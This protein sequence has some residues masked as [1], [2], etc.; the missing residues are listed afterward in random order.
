[1][2][3]FLHTAD[4]QLGKPFARVSDPDK[5][6]LLRQERIAAIERIAVVAREQHAAFVLVAGDIFDSPVATKETVS[7]ACA[8]IGA[9]P[10]P[11]FAI[12]GNHDH[13]GPGSIWEQPF[14]FSEKN[15]LAP[16]LTVCLEAKP[17]ELDAAVLLPCPLLR[18]HESTDTTAWLRG[19]DALPDKP[20]IV[21][22]H[23]SVRGFSTPSEDDDFG[24]GDA[25]NQI[26][27]TRLPAGAF[28]YVALGDWHGKKQVGANA[29]Y[30]G[31]PE[32]DRFPRG[33]GNQ[34][35]HVLVVTVDRGSVPK[36]EPVRTARIGWYQHSENLLDDSDLS[37]LEEKVAALLGSRAQQDLLRLELRGQ[38][39]IEA[40]TQL[41]QNL[42]AWRARLLRLKL[43]RQIAVAPSPAEIESLTRRA[44]DPL[45]SRVSEKLLALTSTDNGDATAHARLAL[46]E[47]HAACHQPELRDS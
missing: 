8:A 20:R 45:I 4:W 25:V 24:D 37:G 3:T 10:V 21:L 39:G 6:A 34:P 16:N 13:G 42:E 22:A 18:R 15:M 29:W 19:L 23:G 47:L 36:V 44:N 32:L 38:L 46:R 27:L 9:I 11:V 33:E 7:A 30:A 1:M 41:E 40:T 2:I 28:D 17:I 35:G 43:D 31:T 5:R 26:D 14:F 12:P